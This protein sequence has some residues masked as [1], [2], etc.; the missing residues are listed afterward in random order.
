MRLMVHAKFLI[1]Y[2]ASAE[3]RISHC[4]KFGALTIVLYDLRQC[5]VMILFTFPLC[6]QILSR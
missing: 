5:S 2:S 4:R 6:N 1:L 3:F